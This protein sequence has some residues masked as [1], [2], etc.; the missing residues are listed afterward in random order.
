MKVKD[1]LNKINCK[2]AQ[3]PVFLQDGAF[4]DYREVTPS[5]L[6]GHHY[7]EKEYTVASISIKDD[8]I[9]VHYIRR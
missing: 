3:Q 8:K 2:T 5:D 6:A 1:I 9:V 4:G 7:D